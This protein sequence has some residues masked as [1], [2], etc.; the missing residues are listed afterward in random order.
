MLTRLQL[1]RDE[2]KPGACFVFDDGAPGGVAGGPAGQVFG[3]GDDHRVGGETHRVDLSGHWWACWQSWKDGAEVLMGW[4]VA[5]EGAV[6][7][8]GTMYFVLHQHGI[9]MVGR[10]VG[11]SYDGPI[12]SRWGAIARTEEEVTEL[13][14]K[15]RRDGT[16]A[17]L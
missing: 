10:W 6:R 13:M 2:Q 14:D 4:Y 9:H 17:V 12:I 15:L 1:G 16:T 11:L 3:A 8:K 7:S 5:D